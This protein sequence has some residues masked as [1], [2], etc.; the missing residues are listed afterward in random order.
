MFQW[1]LKK[2][3]TRIH[4]FDLPAKKRILVGYVGNNTSGISIT[5]MLWT[6]SG[7]RLLIFRYFDS[8]KATGSHSAIRVRWEALSKPQSTLCIRF[9]LQRH[10]FHHTESFRSPSATAVVVQSATMSASLHS[11]HLMHVNV[12]RT[13]KKL[14][15]WKH[16]AARFRDG[17]RGRPSARSA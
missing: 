16:A 4:F 14:D 17:S 9:I 11:S 3:D 10:E 2:G 1:H 13:V 12:P 7:F 8:P 15:R 6:V 5:A